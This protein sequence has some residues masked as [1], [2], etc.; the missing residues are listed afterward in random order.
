VNDPLFSPPAAIVRP[1]EDLATLAAEINRE[2]EAA[3]GSIRQG[4]GHARRA[5]E[6]LLRA[7]AQCGHGRWLR[8]LR[9]HCHFSERTGRAYM[10][11][12]RRWEDLQAKRQGLADLTFEG[13]LKFLAAPRAP[14]ASAIAPMAV[15]LE[16]GAL[17]EYH[18][19]ALEVLRSIYTPDLSRTLDAGVYEEPDIT[20][21]DVESMVNQLRPEEH[22]TL[23]RLGRAFRSPC[24]LVVVT[25]ARAFQEQAQASGGVLPQWKVASFW[26]AT[27]A[28]LLQLQ[29]GQVAVLI[30]RW[31]E[32]YESCLAWWGMW[33]EYGPWGGRPE[34]DCYKPAM[35]H[36][37]WGD[38]IHSGSVDV[39]RQIQERMNAGDEAAGERYVQLFAPSARREAWI[40]PSALQ[41]RP[42]QH[43][44]SDEPDDQVA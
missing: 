7:K 39:P 11:V 37:V 32:R 40:L 4:L 13:S 30:E 23:W 12:A 15:Y 36:A 10:Q 34:K 28:V 31:R 29:V 44:D 5:G 20:E 21:Q 25:A 2:H 16:E 18:A 24:P 43:H 27:H 14:A 9:E 8:W 38:L 1:A 42:P 26:W 33:G 19:E 3:E 22:P 17:S 35:Y 6:L 41:F